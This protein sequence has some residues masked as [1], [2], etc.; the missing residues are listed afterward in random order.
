MSDIRIFQAEFHL[1]LALH[2]IGLSP[3]WAPSPICNSHHLQLRCSQV[4]AGDIYGIEQQN[5]QTIKLSTVNHQLSTI[6]Y[7][8][9]NHQLSTIN[10]QQSTINYQTSNKT[11]NL[12]VE[13]ALLHKKNILRQCSFHLTRRGILGSDCMTKL[14]QRVLDLRRTWD[15]PESLILSENKDCEL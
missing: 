9:I 1:C 12:K 10:N 5:Y 6:K 14:V 8:T 15:R 3:F 7:Q 4:V 2:W 13:T 11:I